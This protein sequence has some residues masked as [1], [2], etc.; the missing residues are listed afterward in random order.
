MD[1]WMDVKIDTNF[2][3]KRQPIKQV[4]LIDIQRKQNTIL[5]HTN[6]EDIIIIIECD[7]KQLLWLESAVCI[8]ILIFYLLSGLSEEGRISCV[9]Y[10]IQL[11][12]VILMM[13]LVLPVRSKTRHI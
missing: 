11:T 8:G 12:V 3:W 4:F 6:L 7:F 13:V 10:V 2:R 5:Y 1:G 9:Y